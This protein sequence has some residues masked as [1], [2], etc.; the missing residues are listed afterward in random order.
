LVRFLPLLT[1]K[2]DIDFLGQSLAENT[3]L[4]VLNLADNKIS[5]FQVRMTLKTKK[6]THQN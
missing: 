5:S 3:E 4:E 6:F 1:N 2:S